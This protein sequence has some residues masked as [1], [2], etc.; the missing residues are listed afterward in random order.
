MIKYCT[1][2]FKAITANQLFVEDL[3]SNCKS[4]GLIIVPSDPSGHEITKKYGDEII[5]IFKAVGINFEKVEYILDKDDIISADFNIQNYSTIFLMGGRTKC[6]NK[7]LKS[8][9]F[10][11]L[12]SKFEGPII[13]QSAG[14]LNLCKSTF[15]SPSCNVESKVE[16]IEGLGMVMDTFEVHF[17]INNRQQKSYIKESST[18]MLCICD[19]GAIKY[20]EQ[21]IVCFGNVYR[22][23][24]GLFELL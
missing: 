19:S 8:I 7:F 6:Q 2:D 5:H 9:D 13:G 21:G 23:S 22:Y 24:D 10:I 4:N 20:D 18:D 16:F 1:S 11:N 17:D 12:V 14:A 15:L 3:K